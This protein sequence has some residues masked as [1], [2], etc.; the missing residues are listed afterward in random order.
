VEEVCQSLFESNPHPMW[1]FDAETLVFLAVNNA[2]VQSYGYSREEFLSMTIKDIRPEADVNHLIRQLSDIT[3]FLNQS[4]E[5][6]HRKKDGTIIDVEITTHGII[7]NGRNARLVLAHDITERK[8]AERILKNNEER[9]RLALEVADMGT[10]ECDLV[11]SR[12]TFSERLEQIYGLAPNT[13]LTYEEFVQLIH[14]EDRDWFHTMTDRAIK[15]ATTC[16]LEFRIVRPDGTLRWVAGKG[17]VYLNENN[18]PTRMVGVAMDVTEQK[19]AEQA[20][21]ESEEQLRQAQKMEAIGKL[22]GGI[23]HDFNNLLTAILVQCEFL[24]KQINREDS[25]HSKIYEIKRAGERAAALTKQ[26][27]AFSRKQVLQPKTLCLNDIV[28]DLNNMLKRL[29]GEHIELITLLDPKCGFV[30]ADQGQLEQVIMNLVVNARD[31][32]P[33]GGKLIIQT[34]N[35][36]LNNTYAQSHV[37]VKPGKYVMLAISDNGIGMDEATKKRIFE[38]FFTT[39]E[40]GKGTGLGLST[41]YGIIKQSGGNIWVYSEP[42]FGSVFK[43]Y[44]P[45]VEENIE[46]LTPSTAQTEELSGAETILLVEDEDMVRQLTREIL[47]LYGYKIL[48][49]QHAKEAISISEQY[50]GPIHMMITDVIMPKT[51]GKELANIL[52]KVRPEMCVLYMSGYTDDAIVHHGVLDKHTNFIQKPFTPE[53]LAQAVKKVLKKLS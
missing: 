4:G 7:F 10:F 24:L 35:V 48:E 13:T 20:L 43:I 37:S 25:I 38:P 16:S 6:Q 19:R 5:W 29:I 28:S 52:S 23:A 41:V 31:A 18:V 51:S 33:Q 49:A 42:K 1:I 11:H 39:K 14:P 36:N 27:L 46:T 47:E 3:P 32:M 40:L 2:A 44:L 17:Q 21:K 34:K 53:T 9:L 12:A 45:H 26:L 15:E 8:R 22:A 30:K 50:N